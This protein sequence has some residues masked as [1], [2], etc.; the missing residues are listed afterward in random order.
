M[1]LNTRVCL[2]LSTELKVITLRLWSTSH[3]NHLGTSV[4]NT[5]VTT[6]YHSRRHHF[7]CLISKEEIS[8]N[9][10]DSDSQSLVPSNIKGG[11]WLQHFSHSNSLCTRATRAIINHAPIGEYRLRFFPKENFSCPCS[12]Y[13]IESQQHILYDCSRFN[14]YWNPRRDLIVHFTL[15]LEF[16]SRAFSFEEDFTT[17]SISIPS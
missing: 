2:L 17:S 13:S 3:A 12:L 10:W 14:N 8:S 7:K 6:L 1:L 4:R 16:N 11:L 15:F 5:S 9:F